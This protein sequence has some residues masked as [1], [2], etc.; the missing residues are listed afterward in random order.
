LKRELTREVLM[1][2]PDAK[3]FE[4]ILKFEPEVDPKHLSSLLRDVS[5]R[6]WSE[7]ATWSRPTDVERLRRAFV[8]LAEAGFLTE[9]EF[10]V[11]LNRSLNEIANRLG[12][13]DRDYAGYVFFTRQ[14]AEQVAES[15]PQPIWLRLNYGRGN[16][17][18]TEPLL[19]IEVV[20]QRV[21]EALRKEGLE[22]EWPGTPNAFIKVRMIWRM[23][24]GSA[25]LIAVPWEAE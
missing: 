17:P 4:Q 11:Y 10:G 5:S 1:G 19:P 3:V 8:A 23:P 9:W 20:A 15:E 16:A 21:V 12:E 13:A 22:V 2:V 7:Q 25:D 24:R 6:V 14:E 18:E